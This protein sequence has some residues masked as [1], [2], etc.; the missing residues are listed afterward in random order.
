MEEKNY[1]SGIEWW[2]LII[3]VLTNKSKDASY[4][5]K[6]CN[7]CWRKGVED[8]DKVCN[9]EIL[10]IVNKLNGKELKIWDIH[11]VALGNFGE[12]RD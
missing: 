12:N 11:D 6:L 10:Y 9:E 1:G 4:L 8:D 3:E 7:K 2:W 5:M